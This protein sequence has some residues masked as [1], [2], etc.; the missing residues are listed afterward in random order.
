[1]CTLKSFLLIDILSN[2]NQ[3][4]SDSYGEGEY[5]ITVN[6]STFFNKN[7]LQWIGSRLQVSFIRFGSYFLLKTDV[8][9][10][11]IC[12]ER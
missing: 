4:E 3:Q 9:C 7:R 10:W 8:L 11:N 5:E 6:I 2:S 1:M 12:M